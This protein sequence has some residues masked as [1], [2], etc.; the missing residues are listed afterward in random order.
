MRK[1]GDITAEMEDVLFLVLNEEVPL[2]T[3]QNDLYELSIDHD[4]QHGEVLA[5]IFSWLNIHVPNSKKFHKQI[6]IYCY[7]WLTL[8]VPEQAE[9]YTAGGKPDLP[10]IF[11]FKGVNDDRRSKP[12]KTKSQSA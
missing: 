11:G 8:N 4:L 5:L 3:L 2:S 10:K 1:V 12:R 9:E 7:R 6:L